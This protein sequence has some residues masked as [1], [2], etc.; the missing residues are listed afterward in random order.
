MKKMAVLALISYRVLPALMGGQKCIASFYDALSNESNITLAVAKE[1]VTTLGYNKID[2]QNFLYN[3]WIGILNLRYIYRLVK[4]IKTKEINTIIVEHSY[5]GWLGLILKKFTKTNLVLRMHNIESFR[6]RDMQ[7]SWWWIYLFYEKWVCRKAQYLWFS[8]PSDQEWMIE[9]WGIQASKCT[10]ILYG[11]NNTEA[12]SNADR[13]ACKKSLQNKHQLNDKIKLFLFN[14]TL[15]YLPNTDA[16]RIIINE[17]IPRLDKTDL[18]YRI[19]ICG[20]RITARWEKVLI[21]YPQIIYEGFVPDINL[22][23]KG[24]DCFINPVTLGNGV[25]TKLVEALSNNQNIISATTGAKGI[26]TKYAG[27]KIQLIA[28]YDWQHFAQAMVDYKNKL[29]NNTPNI[30]LLILIGTTLCIKQWNPLIN[31]IL[32]YNPIAF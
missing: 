30:F 24:T 9:N 3:H 15:D 27:E 20:N 5:F 6:F 16:I 14:G 31:T 4:I 25:K 19:F 22:Y 8:S 13:L 12:P 7:K 10:T 2:I 17:I 11:I 18:N 29:T 21:Q 32:T 1:N 28:D 23:F 26:D